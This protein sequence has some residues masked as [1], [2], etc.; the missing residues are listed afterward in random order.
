MI[1]FGLQKNWKVEN[2][3]RIVCG[4]NPRMDATFLDFPS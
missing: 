4:M 2:K 1:L 3:R